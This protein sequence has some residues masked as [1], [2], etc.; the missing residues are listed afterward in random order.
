MLS[1]LLAILFL[2]TA[3]EPA[4]EPQKVVQEAIAYLRS[5][6]PSP[7]TRYVDW[8]NTLEGAKSRNYLP[9]LVLLQADTPQSLERRS[10]Q[11]LKDPK[12]FTRKVVSETTGGQLA[13]FEN[14]AAEQL[15]NQLN[16]LFREYD[17][18]RQELR[19]NTLLVREEQ[20]TDNRAII[21]VTPR[22]PSGRFRKALISLKKTN[23]SWLIEPFRSQVDR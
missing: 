23:S 11:A 8:Q 2:I 7:V 6:D 18:S 3:A 4:Q 9:L 21:S 16:P 10:A 20:R 17:Q 22:T 13:L 15:N 1:T 19:R 14:L 5:D 12:G